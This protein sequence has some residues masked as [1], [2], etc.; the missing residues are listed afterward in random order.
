MAV[1]SILQRFIDPW[2]KRDSHNFDAELFHA[3]VSQGVE[4]SGMVQ[5]KGNHEL[6]SL[7]GRLQFNFHRGNYA[8]ESIETVQR[9]IHETINLSNAEDWGLE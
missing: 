9:F 6:S 5:V 4:T 2:N 8:A 3:L 7:V 1:N